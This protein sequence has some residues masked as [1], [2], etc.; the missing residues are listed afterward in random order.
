MMVTRDDVAKKAGVS[1]ATVSRAYNMPGRVARDKVRRVLD[2][3]EQLGYVPDKNASALRRNV[4]GSVLFLEK[5]TGDID[6]DTPFYLWFYADIIRNVKKVIDKSIY[7]LTLHSFSGPSD[8]RKI[9]KLRL[10]DGIIGYDFGD[11]KDISLLQSLGIPYVVCRQLKPVIP[12]NCSYVDEYRGGGVAGSCFMKTGHTRPAHITGNLRG[13]PICQARW[14]GFRDAVRPYDPIL[15]DGELGIRGG[16]A[17]AMKLMPEIRKRAV[18]S[19]FVV[20]DLTAVGVVQ[21]LVNE[22]IH[23][24]EDLSVIGYDNLPF[25]KT[26]PFS[27]TTIDIGL[28]KTY[29]QAARLLLAHLKDPSQCIDNPVVPQLVTGDSVKTRM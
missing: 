24:P 27:L 9:G 12:C 6:S 7:R 3:A 28:G 22:G 16:F 20:N 4:S 21:A 5:K 23:V 10:A 13:I 14:E 2:A 17:S 26:L 29:F 18:D 25:I 11:E 8:L 19:I 15:I 1:S